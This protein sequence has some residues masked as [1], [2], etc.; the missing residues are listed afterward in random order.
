MEYPQRA[1]PTT[2][3][4]PCRD[5]ALPLRV[6]ATLAVARIAQRAMLPTTMM[7]S[8]R[9]VSSGDRKGRPYKQWHTIYNDTVHSYGEW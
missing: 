6:G 7:F 8:R 2:T 4:M 5:D 1:M 9:A 3:M